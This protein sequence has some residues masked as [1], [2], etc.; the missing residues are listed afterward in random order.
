MTP[1]LTPAPGRHEQPRASANPY[2]PHTDPYGITLP[3][4]PVQPT[5]PPPAIAWAVMDS[6][7]KMQSLYQNKPPASAFPASWVIRPLTWLDS[8][9]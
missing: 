1:P 4:V 6:R 2:R 7:G 5:P 8:T 3:I 9:P